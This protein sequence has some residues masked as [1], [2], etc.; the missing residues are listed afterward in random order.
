MHE[1]KPRNTEEIMSYSRII[2]QCRKK[3]S[4]EHIKCI[5]PEIIL[6]KNQKQRG[7]PETRRGKSA[8][9]SCFCGNNKQVILL[10]MLGSMSYQLIEGD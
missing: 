7:T 4:R 10:K 6:S 8:E 3:Q 5:F 1:K 9:E 2:D